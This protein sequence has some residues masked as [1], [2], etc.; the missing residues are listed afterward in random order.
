MRDPAAN[1]MAA[2][3]APYTP[4]VASRTVVEAL[5]Y[6]NWSVLMGLALGSL[7][8]AYLLAQL[9]DATSGYLGFSAFCAGLLGLL[10]LATDPSLPWHQGLVVDVASQL[11]AAR[12]AALAAF[13]V[14]AFAASIRLLRGGK[15]RWLG[16][17]A[18][19]CGVAAEAIAAFGWA[20]DSVHGVPLTVQFLML[21]VVSGGALGAVVLAHWYLVTPRISERP[22]IL[23]TRLLTLALGIQLLLFLT[24]QA[25]GG[26]PAFSSFTGNQ[27]LFVWLRLT[28]GLLF[29]LALS[30]MAYRTAVTRSMESATGLLYIDLAAIL[31]STIV[32]AALYYAAAL[33]V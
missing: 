32:A 8:L 6:I 11:D 7:G 14:L 1:P 30:Y 19:A 27:A 13:V 18:L 9:S 5:P 28:V 4:A 17:A 31:A 3:G 16:L 29:P 15:A 21:S 12:R 26:G 2:R 22:L 23:T 25:V 24:W 33:L 10:V 20:G